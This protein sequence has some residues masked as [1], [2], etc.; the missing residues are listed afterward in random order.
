MGRD[1]AVLAD[2]HGFDLW[3]AAVVFTL[4]VL[5]EFRDRGHR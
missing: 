5:E 3:E 2:F 1:P 4:A